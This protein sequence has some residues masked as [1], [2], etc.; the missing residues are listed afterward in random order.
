[1]KDIDEI[2]LYRESGF[3]CSYCGEKILIWQ[4]VNSYWQGFH[5]CEQIRGCKMILETRE[6]RSPNSALKMTK[7]FME[8]LNV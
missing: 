1:M 4:T 3:V 7:R 2:E 5:E 8:A 6:Y